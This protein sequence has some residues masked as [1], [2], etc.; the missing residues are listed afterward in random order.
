MTVALLALA[1]GC[2]GKTQDSNGEAVPPDSSDTDTVP[3]LPT[4][5]FKLVDAQWIAP[6][7]VSFLPDDPVFVSVEEHDTTVDFFLTL[8]VH[9]GKGDWG[10]QSPL[11]RTLR[12]SASLADDG[13]F[14]FGPQDIDEQGIDAEMMVEELAVSGVIT[15]DRITSIVVSGRVDAA[16]IY[17]P[18]GVANAPALC[19][20]LVDYG[21]TCEPCA[22]G[23]VRCVPFEV[24]QTQA[25]RIEMS[26][27]LYEVASGS[28]CAGVLLPP[29]GGLLFR[30]RRRK[31]TA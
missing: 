20:I 21:V 4:Y 29:L 24:H 16:G 13:S 26:G 17:D 31:A 25:P 14:A 6:A 22:D 12:L 9:H 7:T 10:Y 1:L 15:P 3:S 27:A 18:T 23:G 2:S 28:W 5:A 8:S 11:H 19:K 30:M